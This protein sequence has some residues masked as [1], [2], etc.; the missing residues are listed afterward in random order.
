MATNRTMNGGVYE[1]PDQGDTFIW[2]QPLS[3]WVGAT[4]NGTLQKTGGS[5][6]LGAETDFGPNFGIKASYFSG[7]AT[8]ADAGLFR[9]AHSDT[10]QFRN[11][12]NTGNNSLSMVGDVLTYSGSITA[13]SFTGSGAGLT[14]LTKASV[15]LGSVDNT[16]DASKPISSAQAAVNANPAYGATISA[17]VENRAQAW[18]NT[19]QANLG[20]QPCANLRADM[21]YWGWTGSALDLQINGTYFGAILPTNIS[22]RAGVATSA[23]NANAVGGFAN[24]AYQD[25]ATNGPY[26]L[27]TNGSN[28]RTALTKPGN[29]NVNSAVTASFASSSGSCSGNAAT[30]STASNSNALGGQGVGYF[31]N[32]G[33]TSVVNIRNNSY[34]QLIAGISGFGDVWWG[35]NV[36]DERLKQNIA[37]TKEDSLSKIKAIDFVEYQ[38]KRL[39]GEMQID[40]GRTHKNGLI[41]QQIEKIDPHWVAEHGTYKQPDQYA[42]QMDSMHA[43]KQLDAIVEKLT[44]LIETQANYIVAIEDRLSALEAKEHKYDIG[45]RHE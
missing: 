22:G 1:I 42:L 21:I 3:D 10:I 16:S 26:L 7:R 31:I 17:N 43:I 39:E 45:G 6:T 14:G 24:W 44:A 27:Y 34:I 41:A 5:F 28:T 33:G 9:L 25:D 8:P 29:L 37:P 38:F 11:A 40:D 36:S 20:Y 4:S 23:D 12:A 19:R 18:A 2:G 15:G 35:V 13:T 32:N 30:A